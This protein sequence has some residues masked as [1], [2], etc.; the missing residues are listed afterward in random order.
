MVGILRWSCTVHRRSCV[1]APETMS[2]A[3]SR[4]PRAM[5]ATLTF[6][7]TSRRATVRAMRASRCCARAHRSG[8]CWPLVRPIGSIARRLPAL[9][10]RPTSSFR[11]GGSRADASPDGSS[12]TAMRW[13]V[14]AD[15]RSISTS[16]QGWTPSQV[17]SAGTRGR[18]NRRR[19]VR[20]GSV[21]AD[22]AGQP[23]LDLYPAFLVP[24]RLVAAV[25]GVEPD[26]A[27]LATIR[28]ESRFLI[29]DER[30]DDLPVVR[31]VDFADQREIAVEDPFLDHRIARDFERIM[32]A[33]TE[34]GGRDR[35]ALG[36]LKRLDRS[37]GG[38]APGKNELHRV[39]GGRCDR[40]VVAF[41]LHL[42]TQVRDEFGRII[43]RASL[44]ELALDL[45]DQPRRKQRVARRDF[46]HLDHEEAAAS[47]IGC[48]LA[49]AHAYGEESLER[50]G[51][52]ALRIGDLDAASG[53]G[54]RWRKR[55]PDTLHCVGERYIA[56]GLCRD[57]GCRLLGPPH[58]L[59]VDPVGRHLLTD[60]R[61]RRWRSGYDLRRRDDGIA[62]VVRE[63]H[64]FRLVI[65][66]HLEAALQ[67]GG[68]LNWKFV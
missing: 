49:L 18:K 4:K 2:E 61:Q 39:V 36:A 14:P 38:D 9:A 56:D 66:R 12:S 7:M 35:K 41:G 29:V 5:T 8:A 11:T 43:L 19:G 16:G 23:P 54:P 10:L 25:R 33:G 59:I 68:E 3:C 30:D 44:A 1:T 63:R 62:G 51:H 57:L 6:S 34:Q 32:F 15:W 48:D 55:R 45:P 21:A 26:H 20:R 46:V 52:I 65:L 42:A 53:N 28:L 37:A 13:H 17:A 47:G 60:A 67:H 31:A 22:Q 40:R 24:L 50:R 27:A 64:H 58:R